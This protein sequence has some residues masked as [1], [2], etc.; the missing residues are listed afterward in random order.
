MQRVDRPAAD[1]R[2]GAVAMALEQRARPARLRLAVVVGEGEQPRPAAAAPALRAAAGPSPPLR[3]HPHRHLGRRRPPAPPPGRPRRRRRRRSPRPPARPRIRPERREAGA[4]LSGRWRVGTTTEIISGRSTIGDNVGRLERR[5]DPAPARRRRLRRRATSAMPR[6]RRPGS[7][8]S[9]PRAAARGADL[10]CDL[11]EPGSIREALAAARPEPS[12]T[13]PARPR[14]RESWDDPAETFAVNADGR[15]QP[16]RG[17]AQREA[18]Q[19]HVLCVSSAEVY[20]EADEAACRSPRTAPL[21]PITPY[22][23]SKAAMELVC[24]QYARAARPADRGHARLQPPRA[25]P[26]D[27]SSRPRASPARSPR[28]RPRGATR[29]SSTVGNLSRRARLH[30][31]ARRRPRLRRGRASAG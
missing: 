7:R 6:P 10:A 25:R 28:P 29:S 27:P 13:S 18:P 14:S 31:R 2:P 15:A 20:G 21:A 30:R 1:Q 4:Q 3:D 19:A 8:W 24:G 17:G 11:L 16:A 22:G 9:A 12:S 26:V 23:A 5:D